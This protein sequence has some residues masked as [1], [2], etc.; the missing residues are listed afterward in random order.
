MFS[1]FKN[2]TRKQEL[3]ELEKLKGTLLEAMRD[4]IQKV[5]TDNAATRQVFIETFAKLATD[6]LVNE[7]E[8]SKQGDVIPS[9]D[10]GADFTIRY[11]NDTARE[12]EAGI[13]RLEWIDK[14]TAID[15]ETGVEW[16]DELW[17]PILH[18]D[19]VEYAYVPPE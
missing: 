15:P 13:H 10:G 5:S 7:S 17:Q 12:N 18:G 2:D 19:A 4:T 9:S 1:F 8:I 3:R 6:D 11:R 14:P 16:A